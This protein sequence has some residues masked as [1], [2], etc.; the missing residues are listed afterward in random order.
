MWTSSYYAG[1]LRDVSKRY[2]KEYIKNQLT[3]YNNGRPRRDSP[4]D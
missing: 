3:K 2:V 1:T 4:Y